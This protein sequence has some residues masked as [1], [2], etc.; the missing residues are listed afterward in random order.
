MKPS[1]KARAAPPEEA[2]S[3][4]HQPPPLPALQSSRGHSFHNCALCQSHYCSLQVLAFLL[5]LVL[6][7][8]CRAKDCYMLDNCVTEELFLEILLHPYQTLNSLFPP[9]SSSSALHGV[10]LFNPILQLKDELSR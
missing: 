4:T 8:L 2:Q 7:L 9:A 3:S 1:N 10:T 5:F 6:Q